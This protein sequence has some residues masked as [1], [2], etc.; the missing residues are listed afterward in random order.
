MTDIKRIAQQDAKRSLAEDAGANGDDP[1]AETV[2]PG[3]RARAEVTVREPGI[4]CGRPWFDAVFQQLD[5]G[6]RATWELDDGDAFRTGQRICTVEASAR[7]LLRGE[8]S[9]I[10]FL[11]TLSGT[12]TTA[13]RVADRAAGTPLRILDTRKTLPGLRQAQ[14]YAVRC[15]GCYNHRM[16][17]AD[18]VM[19]K[20]NH[21][22]FFDSLGDAARKARSQAPAL[23]LIIEVE[24]LEQL[25][26]ALDLQVSHLLLDNFS[27][28][29]LRAAV[30]RNGGRAL[31][32]AS[33]NVNEDNLA[34]IVATGITCV[35]MGAL[36]KHVRAIDFSMRIA[37]AQDGLE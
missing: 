30:Q 25:Q 21:L 6:A 19:L 26:E 33:G 9:A 22:A 20:E 29:D 10:N 14:K 35:S 8:R 3:R 17:L 32:E 24:T 5:S 16:G 27:L 1:S 37:P 34:E 4:L 12:A 11:Q 7:A 2:E 13:R 23:P 28:E 18:A 15:G 36:T 31:L